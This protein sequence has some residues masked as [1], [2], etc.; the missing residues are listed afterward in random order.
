MIILK[1]I[2]TIIYDLDGTLIDTN[3]IIVRSFQST[4]KKHFPSLKISLSKIYSFIG[5]TLHDT[6]SK[7]TDNPFL[8]EEMIRSYR[9]FYV[10]YEVGSHRLY[11]NVIQVI[12][13]LKQKGYQLAVL[14]SKFKEAAWPSYTHYGLDK[15]FDEF[16]GLD[17]VKN[18]KPHPDAI[19]EV[20]KRFP[21]CVGAI[22]IG[23]NQ[24]DILAGKNAG[25]YSAGVA[26]SLKGTNHLLE[27]SPDFILEDMDDIFRV[28]KEIEVV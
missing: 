19:N 27:V 24:G 6:F 1:K 21:T 10:K 16:V 14:T 5:P 9:E 2:D 8:I 17:D 20:L 23:D 4:F 25:I 11:P 15:L 22:M 12:K 7:Y 18:P 26:W 28:L 13:K 3:N